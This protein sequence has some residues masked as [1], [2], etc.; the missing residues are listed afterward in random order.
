MIKLFYY[1]GVC[2]F[3]LYIVLEWI[4]VF[5]EVQLVEFG[6]VELLVV[7]FLGMVLVL[8]EDDGWVLMQVG[9]ILYYLVV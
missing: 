7:N 8:I 9:V 6:L 1:I 2:L 3:V 4:G 5:Y